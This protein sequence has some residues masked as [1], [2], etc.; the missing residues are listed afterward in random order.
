MMRF[1]GLP[2][3]FTTVLASR[4]IAQLGSHAGYQDPNTILRTDN[5]TLGPQVEEFHYYYDQ[6]PIGLAVSSKGRLFVC[7]TRGTYQYTLGEAVNNTAEVSDSPSQ[8]QLL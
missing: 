6:W 5:G 3:L 4:A 8:L 1:L 7:Y 2:F